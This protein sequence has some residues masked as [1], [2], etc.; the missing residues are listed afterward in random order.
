MESLKSLPVIDSHVHIGNSIEAVEDAARFM[1]KC[2]YKSINIACLTGAG[3]ATVDYL[4]QNMTAMLLKA[5]YHKTYAYGGLNH[6]LKDTDPKELRFAEQAKRLIDLGFDGIKMLEGKPDARK[7]IGMRLDS[8]YYDEYYEYLQENSIPLLFH[9]ADPEEFWDPVRVPSWAKDNGWA[10]LDGT[11]PEYDSLYAEVDG[12]LNKFPK[13]NV[14]FAHFYFMS[15]SV[16]RAS[17]FLDKW[18][19]V[20][21]DI[22]PGSEMYINFSR[23]VDRWHDFFVKYQDRIIYG[24]DSMPG[25]APYEKAINDALNLQNNVRKFLETDETY[26]A[27][28]GE[29]KGIALEDDVLEKIYYK[30]FIKCT[31]AEPKKID[32]NLAFDE[33]TR[34][35]EIAKTLPGQEGIIEMEEI[36]KRLRISCLNE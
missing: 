16:E 11:F 9:V 10:Y 29:V 13:L 25:M 24:T 22:T 6:F 3:L 7:E 34:C 30:N 14:R 28:G 17:E 19:T 21:F 32:M 35:L 27:F 5:L 12:I 26:S 1:D 23:D 4:T 33:C 18:P 20:N 8:P 31:S 36:Y 2:G 15:E